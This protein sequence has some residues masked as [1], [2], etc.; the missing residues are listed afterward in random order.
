MRKYAI[1][2]IYS[3]NIESV[4]KLQKLIFITCTARLTLMQKK[5]HFFHLPPSMTYFRRGIL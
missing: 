3:L 2:S 1:D 4:V 5:L